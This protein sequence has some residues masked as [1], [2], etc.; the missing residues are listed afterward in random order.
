MND[1]RQIGICL[2]C[3]LIGRFPLCFQVH[4]NEWYHSQWYVII[5]RSLHHDIGNSRADFLHEN[6]QYKAWWLLSRPY[7]DAL[8]CRYAEDSLL[9]LCYK[10]EEDGGV[11]TA[12]HPRRLAEENRDIWLKQWQSHTLKLH[13]ICDWSF[14]YWDLFGKSSL[15]R[16]IPWRKAGTKS[17]WTE[18]IMT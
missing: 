16:V 17:F 2:F 14:L 1:V 5:D 12:E 6:R 11:M 13:N 18:L 8:I 3:L 4:N 7:L 9:L 10:E 15:F